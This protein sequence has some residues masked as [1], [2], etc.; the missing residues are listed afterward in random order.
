[1]VYRRNRYQIDTTIPIPLALSNT[2]NPIEQ[3]AFNLINK[4]CLHA[5]LQQTSPTQVSITLF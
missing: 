3:Q 1:M 2:I 4:N 5:C